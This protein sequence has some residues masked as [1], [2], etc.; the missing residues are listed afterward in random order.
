MLATHSGQF[1]ADELFAIS[2]ISF[3]Q[4]HEIVRTR[5][6]NIIN[7][8]DLVLDVGAKYEPETGY[9]DHHQNS[10]TRERDNGIPYATAGI[11][12]EYYGSE[13]FKVKGLSSDYEIDFAINWV[14]TKLIQD[15]DAV[16]NGLYTD[17]PRP[18]V[19]LIIAMMN[20]K[21]SSSDEEK[22]AAF[23]KALSF[24]KEILDNFIDRAISEAQVIL[25][26]EQ[27]ANNIQDGILILEKNIP[28]KDFL[29]TQ[30]QIKRVV[31]PRE[32]DNYGV[33]CNGQENHLPKQ[34]RGL[35]AEELNSVTGF[36]DAVFCHKSGFMAVSKSK[37]TSILIAQLQ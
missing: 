14:D 22:Q 29:R 4:K 7:S 32:N 16:D 18:S 11:I 3:I 20:A 34:I 23:D 10:F 33:F 35:Q 24:T 8:A 17:N 15:I 21:S 19:S 28:F 6:E 5:D 1:H 12:W 27:A 9:F 25:E 2:M 13:I 26:L 37:E 36:D 30:P 31:Y